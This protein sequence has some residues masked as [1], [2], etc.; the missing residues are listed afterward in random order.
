MGDSQRRIGIGHQNEQVHPGFTNGEAIQRRLDEGDHRR[1]GGWGSQHH[2][3]VAGDFWYS[4]GVG[5]GLGHDG[6]E[7]VG[8]RKDAGGPTER[9]AG[10]ELGCQKANVADQGVRALD[11]DQVL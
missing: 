6:L 7:S 4:G 11:P 3:A 8:N 2:L 5:I 9:R 1:N 10:T